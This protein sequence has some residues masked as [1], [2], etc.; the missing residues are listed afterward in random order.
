VQINNLAKI[1]AQ[2]AQEICQLAAAG[3]HQLSPSEEA[4][5]AEFLEELVGA[6]RLDEAV[7]FVAFGLPAREAV[8]WAC[9][10][11]RMELQ[12]QTPEP[13]L[14]ALHAAEI[15]VRKPTDEHRRAAMVRAQAAKFESPAAWAA[16]AAFWSSGSMAPP[17]LP[18]VPAAPHLLGVAVLGAVTLAAVLDTPERADERRERYIAAAV[19]IANG[20][21][22][23]VGAAG[24]AGGAAGAGG[25]AAGVT[26][27]GARA[28]RG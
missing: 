18:A 20:G 11:A 16:V 25:S 28:S 2:K 8:W 6:K 1:T 12:E 26:G 17:D 4:S 15:W 13:V 3:G 24:A 27:A 19:N 23:N 21:N 7:K 10:C 5:P 14:A 22:G 9:V